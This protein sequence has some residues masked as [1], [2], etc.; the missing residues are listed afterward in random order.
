MGFQSQCG[1]KRL[2]DGSLIRCG[3]C[4]CVGRLVFGKCRLDAGICTSGFWFCGA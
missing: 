4:R 2:V 1:L 3:L